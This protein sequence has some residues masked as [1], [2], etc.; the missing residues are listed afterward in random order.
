MKEIELILKHILE[1]A[2]Q[3]TKLR[4]ENAKDRILIEEFEGRD[5]GFN[6]FVEMGKLKHGDKIHEK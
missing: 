1:R 6:P 4:A 5:E 2:K 3:I